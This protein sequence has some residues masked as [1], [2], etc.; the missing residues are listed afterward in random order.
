MPRPNASVAKPGPGAVAK[1]IPRGGEAFF[2]ARG[3]G[4]FQR[5]KI[6]TFD[7]WLT[8]ALKKKLWEMD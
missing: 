1:F 3:R 5:R 2:F 6:A 4:G 7:D 8:P